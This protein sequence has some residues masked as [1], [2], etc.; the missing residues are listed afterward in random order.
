MPA[1]FLWLRVNRVFQET[2]TAVGFFNQ[3][4]GVPNH[5][6]NQSTNSFNQDQGCHFPTVEDVV[7]N[8][9]FFNDD[10]SVTVVI[11]NALINAL[12]SSARDDDSV[13]M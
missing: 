12:V 1:P 10:T 3:R 7:P 4:I 8:G 9:E 5:S 2:N 11:S 6:V 13:E